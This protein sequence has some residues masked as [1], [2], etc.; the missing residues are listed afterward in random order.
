MLN[1][2][3]RSSRIHLWVDM[4]GVITISVIAVLC[5]ATGVAPCLPV[6]L[7]YRHLCVGSFLR[8]AATAEA[9]LQGGANDEDSL[10]VGSD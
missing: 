5:T 8:S 2:L 9:D 1:T 6:A 3:L 7:P 4:F 10:I